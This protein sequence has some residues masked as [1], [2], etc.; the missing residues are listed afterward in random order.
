[1]KRYLAALPLLLLLAAC[2]P[3]IE[4]PL[5]LPTLVAEPAA[6]SATPT[7]IPA[8]PEAAPT[9]AAE[10]ASAT[11][12]AT[13][14]VP[15]ATAT[16]PIPIVVTKPLAPGRATPAIILPPPINDPINESAGGLQVAFVELGDTLNVRSGPGVNFPVVGELSPDASGLVMDA[17]T[18]ALVGDDTWVYIEGP[19]GMTGYVNSRYLTE[20]VPPSEYVGNPEMD[21]VLVGL[22]QAIANRDGAALAALVHPER[23]LRLRQGWWNEEIQIPAAEVAGLFTDQAVYDWGI[24]DGSGLPIRGTF[25]DVLLPL[26]DKDLVPAGASAYA[27]ILAGPTA[28]L[29]VLP[30]GYEAV[31]YA[32]FFRATPSSEFDWGTWVV[33]VE[34]WGGHYYLSYLVHYAYEI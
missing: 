21:E 27:E 20:A 18:Q 28:G 6:S 3:Q 19:E 15:S 26:L 23:G 11:V 24:A 32:S 10:V 8:T 34:R 5:V 22:R 14:A 29:V 31:P 2:Q 30:E 13:A 17:A 1:M 9:T 33:G 16:L 7:A 12:A 4:T 25:G